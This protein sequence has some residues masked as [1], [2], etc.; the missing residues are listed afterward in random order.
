MLMMHLTSLKSLF[1]DWQPPH[2]QSD[3][4]MALLCD[5]MWHTRLNS[6]ML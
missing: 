3:R 1:I 5:H 4:D 2:I 6:I